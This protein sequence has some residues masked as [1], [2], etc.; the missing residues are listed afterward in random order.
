MPA[1]GPEVVLNVMLDMVRVYLSHAWPFALLHLLVLLFIV[2]GP[3]RQI[4]KEISALNNWREDKP[5]G[6]DSAD[7]LTQFVRE[8]AH[9]GK[10][11]ILVPMTDFSDRLDSQINALIESLHSRINMFLV[12]GIAGTFFALF[13]FAQ[14]AARTVGQ[15][16]APGA[17]ATAAT[18]LS[19]MLANALAQAFPVGFVG[20]ML[21]VF[22]HLAAF[23]LGARF[24]RAVTSATR[25]AM[26]A[27]QRASKGPAD[28]IGDSL[29]PLE[30]LDVTLR[31]RLQPVIEGF[32]EQL[33]KTSALIRDQIQP[34]AAA[35]SGFEG[36]VL[37]LQ[38]TAQKLTDSAEAIPGALERVQA[39][40][41]EAHGQLE[42]ARDSIDQIRK[43]SQDAAGALQQAAVGMAELPPRLETAFS[44]SLGKMS[45]KTETLWADSNR[46]FFE[47]LDVARTA[48]V[49]SADSLAGAATSLEGAPERLRRQ[50]EEELARLAKATTSIW[51]E[52]SG[53]FWQEMEPIQKEL[54]ESAQAMLACAVELNKSP[55]ALVRHFGEELS[56]L[57]QNCTVVWRETGRE[58][59]TGVQ[60]EFSEA[61]ENLRKLTAETA[62]ELNQAARAIKVLGNHAGTVLTDALDRF[63]QNAAKNIGPRLAEFDEALKVRCPEVLE[64]LRRS[65]EE[66]KGAKEGAEAFRQEMN[67]I[68]GDVQRARDKWAE[69]AAEFERRLKQPVTTRQPGPC[70]GGEIVEIRNAVKRLA[71]RFARPPWY[72]KAWPFGPQ[73]GDTDGE[74]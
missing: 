10:H 21:T 47:N 15:S 59:L 70:D 29:K 37:A 38:P 39:M 18:Q 23:M 32:R 54:R 6:S 8:T 73:M 72:R 69:L 24:E 53:R 45:E 56:G 14:D 19:H 33:D 44:D 49:T 36:A 42:A 68:A 74:V 4:E 5:G 66:A 34:L 55:A 46:R 62:E 7:I 17:T 35:V 25:R 26:D 57:A 43:A 20:L 31:D 22:G 28:L 27:R 1:I 41:A 13:Q 51:Q 11:G 48:F 30:N 63:L 3:I 67:R 2:A 65:V 16:V 9:W 61:M 58:F 40:Q 60:R 71:E 64:A 12:I 50:F 52:A